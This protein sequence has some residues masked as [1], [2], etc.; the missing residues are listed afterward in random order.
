[1]NDYDS[2]TRYKEPYIKSYINSSLYCW[3]FKK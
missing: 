1:M 3:A 2:K